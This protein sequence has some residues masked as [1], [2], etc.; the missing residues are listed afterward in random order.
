MSK[1][2]ISIL[3]CGWLGLPLGAKLSESGLIV[4]G[5]TTSPHKI[6]ILRNTGID[7]FIISLSNVNVEGNIEDFLSVADVLIID[8]P[9]KLRSTSEDFVAKIR[10]LIP[11]IIKSEIAHVLFVSSTAVYADNNSIVTENTLPNSETE[12]GR[13][14]VEAEKLLMDNPSFRTTI[15]RFGGLIGTDRHPVKFLSG[16]ENI[17]NPNA[18]VNLIHQTDCIGIICHILETGLWGQI[19]NAAAPQHPTRENYYTEKA[20]SHA[21]PIPIFDHTTKSLGKTID[22]TKIIQTGYTF[23]EPL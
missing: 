11:F 15:L 18:P 4:K 6:E 3:G 9:P 17:E 14:L 1:L 7:P 10:L 5:S 2:R 13:Q 16:R 22:P 12:S 20:K 19:Y 8:I 23:L 21:L